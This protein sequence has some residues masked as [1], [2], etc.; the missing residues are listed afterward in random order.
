MAIEH[1]FMRITGPAY[2]HDALERFRVKLVT[3]SREENASK[4]ELRILKCFHETMKDSRQ[5]ICGYVT[6][7]PNQSPV[8]R[9]F[10]DHHGAVASSMWI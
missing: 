4:Q 2:S 9:S 8:V 5:I 1:R 6:A 10:Q 3:G 7:S